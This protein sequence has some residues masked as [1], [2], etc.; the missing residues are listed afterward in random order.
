MA[1]AVVVE[2][3]L[4]IDTVYEHACLS[5]MHYLAFNSG[6]YDQHDFDYGENKLDPNVEFTHYPDARIVPVAVQ[7]IEQV[8]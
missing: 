2:G 3:K 4:L 7:S 6:D 8:H 1:F 5:K